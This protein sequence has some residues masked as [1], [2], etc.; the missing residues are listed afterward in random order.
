[1]GEKTETTK[2]FGMKPEVGRWMYVLIGLLIQ[3]CLGAV[4]AYSTFKKP[5]MYYYD[6]N[7]FGSSLPFI[8]F[9]A[10]FAALMYFGGRLIQKYGPWKIALVGGILV[11][12]GW[13]SA[14]YTHSLLTLCLTYG[15]IAGAGVGLAYGAPIQTST[16]WFPDLKGLA[17]GLTVGGFG[18]SAAIIS[19]T[20]KRLLDSHKIFYEDLGKSFGDPTFAF[21]IFGI[22]FFTLIVL[23]ALTL[24]FPPAN[25][26]PA[27]WA[28]PKAGAAVATNFKPGQMVKTTS[29][30][31]LML[32]FIFGATA[33]L[34]AIGIASPVGT[35]VVGISASLASSL[36]SVF[37]VFNFTGRPVFGW[38][39]DRFKPRTAAILSF[40]LI[41]LGGG[42]MLLAGM[43]DKAL[44]IACFA[45]LWFALGGWLAIAPTSTV[46]FFGAVNNAT[47]YGIVFLSYGLGA[48]IGNVVSN[49]AKDWFDNYDVA[50][51][52]VFIMAIVGIFLA[53]LLLKAPK[54]GPDAETPAKPAA[55]PPA[56]K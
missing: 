24:R 53:A 21:K 27:G 38:I 5:I 30:W 37:A 45:M 1:M 19:P 15:L 22:I 49:K 20:G 14:G 39:T 11:G 35:E 34:L 40:I 44:Y 47:N 56:K 26:K 25:W 12:I 3:L 23:L 42:G 55:A 43:N 54:K 36:I 7:A 29:F 48:I 13:F 10:T 50:F 33:G 2:V 17:V 46:N 18:L 9:L 8:I 51:W 52:M 4:Y 16:R 31:A 28:G 32:C 6:T 41:G